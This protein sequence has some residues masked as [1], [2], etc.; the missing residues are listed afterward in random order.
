MV[1]YRVNIDAYDGYELLYDDFVRTMNEY[2]A[3]NIDLLD[4][5]V[6][7]NIK[8]VLAISNRYSNRKESL[9]DIFQ[10]GCIGLIKAIN[11]F[12]VSL[13]LQFSTYAVPMISGE[14]KR[15]LRDNGSVKVSRQIKDLAYQILKYKEEYFND[16]GIELDLYDISSKLDIPIYK[17]K[18]AM[19]ST[20]DV[21][22]LFD[23]IKNKK[24]D[25]LFLIDSISDVSDSYDRRINKY[26]LYD[27]IN[28]LNELEKKIIVDRYYN[29][30]TQ[31]EL[32]GELMVSQAQISRLEKGAIKTL[33]SFF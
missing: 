20:M 24:N 14:I 28:S 9:D 2:R 10:V 15:Y 12:D 1:S 7:A 5:L 18:E 13:G 25:D 3:G 11:N 19:D 33:K 26:T 27:G 21:S 8:L 6:K 17:V 29:D 23:K 31:E 4:V 22:S 16:T 32:A 30:K